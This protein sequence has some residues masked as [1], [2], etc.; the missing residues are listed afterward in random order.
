VCALSVLGLHQAQCVRFQCPRGGTVS[1]GYRVW[2][3]P[4][5][6]A[7][8]RSL[9]RSLCALW[10]SV[11]R[12][13]GTLALFWAVEMV[14]LALQILRGCH[15]RA[16]LLASSAILA[17]VFVGC[18]HISWAAPQMLSNEQDFTSFKSGGP[19]RSTPI[20]QLH[21]CRM[22]LCTQL[23]NVLMNSDVTLIDAPSSTQPCWRKGRAASPPSQTRR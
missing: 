14:P 20:C 5:N 18:D 22:R 21:V 2:C 15:I 3:G 23:H 19:T 9:T 1:T 17:R 8:A 16:A 6:T 11:V 7:K 12:S 13:R 4:T 10:H